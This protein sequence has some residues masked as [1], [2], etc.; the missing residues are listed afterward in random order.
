LLGMGFSHI[1]SN[2]SIYVK[3]HIYFCVKVIGIVFE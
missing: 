3:F 1:S 2:Y